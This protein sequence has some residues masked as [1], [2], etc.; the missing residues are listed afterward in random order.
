MSRLML[1]QGILFRCKE[2]TINL[3]G[4]VI[5][6]LRISREAFWKEGLIKVAVFF[7]FNFINVGL[8]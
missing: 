6:R 7:Y 4:K 2:I 5:G 1:C 8:A 3:P